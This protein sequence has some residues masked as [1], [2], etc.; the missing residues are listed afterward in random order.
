MKTGEKTTQM[1]ARLL[2]YDNALKLVKFINGKDKDTAHYNSDNYANITT[3][4]VSMQLTNKRFIEVGEFLTSLNVR[5]E[6][7]NE[8][9]H[10]VKEQIVKILKAKGV[11]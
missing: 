3:G 6:I 1:Y 7:C 9:P 10:K 4:G 5:Y 2:N 11:I 8:P